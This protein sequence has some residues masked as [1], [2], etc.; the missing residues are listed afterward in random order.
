MM[1]ADKRESDHSEKSWVIDSW[2]IEMIT[3][4]IETRDDQAVM[5]DA[6]HPCEPATLTALTSAFTNGDLPR[7]SGKIDGRERTQ[8]GDVWIDYLIVREPTNDI[9]VK[10]R[11][12]CPAELVKNRVSPTVETMWDEIVECVNADNGVG[13]SVSATLGGADRRYHRVIE[14]VRAPVEDVKRVW[15]VTLDDPD[16]TSLESTAENSFLNSPR[17]ATANWG[18]HPEDK[19]ANELLA[20]IAE[21]AWKAFPRGKVAASLTAPKRHKAMRGAAGGYK[22]LDKLFDDK[23]I[24]RFFTY[25]STGFPPLHWVEANL[26]PK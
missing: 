26:T 4:W 22:E 16:E 1:L 3:V 2:S 11:R 24:Q 8:L 19:L 18:P 15:P 6:R 23:A 7:S 13:A 17:S 20:G 12:S 5:R 21:L 14:D 25:Y 10:S 9:V